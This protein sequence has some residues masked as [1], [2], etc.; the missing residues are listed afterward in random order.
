M[1]AVFNSSPLIFLSRLNIINQVLGLF[2]EVVIPGYVKK[3]IFR[4]EDIV[5]DKVKDLLRL[6]NVVEVGAKNLRMVDAFCRKLGKG[7]SEAIVVAIERSADLVILDDHVAREEA[8][9]VGLNVKGTL[10]VIRKL[11]ELD[12]IQCDPDKLHR[13]L[14][15]MKFRVKRGIFDEIFADGM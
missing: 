11:M 9:R 2:S 12:V 15:E 4:K 13:D 8:T 7:E 10:G 6:N 1:I 14:L 3:E 5:S